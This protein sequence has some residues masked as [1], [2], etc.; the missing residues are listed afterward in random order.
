M[1]EE[2]HHNELLIFK[3]KS[4]LNRIM[5]SMLGIWLHLS[6]VIFQPSRMFCINNGEGE[7]GG[8]YRTL[9]PMVTLAPS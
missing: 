7:A 3:R 6:G 9:D 8:I 5:F 1:R 2:L 4:A